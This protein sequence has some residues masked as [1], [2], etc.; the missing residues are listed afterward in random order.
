MSRTRMGP[1]ACVVLS[2]ALKDNTTIE[3]LLLHD[4]PL[5]EVGAWHLMAAITA[6]KNLEYIG[7]QG[8]NFISTGGDL[9]LAGCLN[10]LFGKGN[11][12][13]VQEKKKKKEIFTGF[14]QQTRLIPCVNHGNDAHVH[15]IQIVYKT[16]PL[17]FNR[18]L[19]QAQQIYVYCCIADGM[20]WAV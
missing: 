3:R 4:N 16:E 18:L 7:L 20:L 11:Q 9:C 10:M 1:A 15:E 2:G 14:G 17:H 5:G 19:L 12:H 8:S 13:M 6:N